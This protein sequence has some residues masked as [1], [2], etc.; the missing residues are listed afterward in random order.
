MIRIKQLI[1]FILLGIFLFNGC[2]AASIQSEKLKDLDFTVVKEEDIPEQLKDEIE[3]K[4]GETF[5]M[6]FMDE[7][8]LYICVGYGEQITGGYSIQV[9]DL[10]LTQNAIYI[11]TNLIAPDKSEEKKVA[12]SYP[13]IV[14]KLEK[15][16]EPVV[17]D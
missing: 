13:Y 7:S 6:T 15:R 17:F 3:K 1:F 12:A 2:S 16:E 14:V 11:D 4:K 5:K 8:Y 10:Y 9:N